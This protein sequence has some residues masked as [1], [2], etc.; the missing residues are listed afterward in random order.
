M[1]CQCGHRRSMHVDR[2]AATL[3]DWGYEPCPCKQFA[4]SEATRPQ[5]VTGSSQTPDS[6]S[7]QSPISSRMGQSSSDPERT[8]NGSTSVHGEHE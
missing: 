2:C 5:E 1:R 4:R 8:G 3:D 7:T 6:G